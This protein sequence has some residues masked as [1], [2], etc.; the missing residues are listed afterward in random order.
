MARKQAKT[1]GKPAELTARE[2]EFCRLYA[3][4]G[5]ATQCYLDAQLP[6]RPTTCGKPDRPT[7]GKMAWQLLKKPEIGRQIGQ[8]RQAA[9]RAAQLGVNTVLEGVRQ[10]A[11]FPRSAVFDR[12]GGVRPPTDWPEELGHLVTAF[13][14]KE[15][16][17]IL[18]DEAGRTERD[19]TGMI[20]RGVTKRVYKIRFAPATPAKRMLAEWLGM[21]GGQEFAATDCPPLVQVILDGDPMS[22]KESSDLLFPDAQTPRQAASSGGRSDGRDVK[23]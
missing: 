16:V 18:R 9:V 20:I 8:F 10:Q 23:S 15:R 7:A 19:E 17:G 2:V 6:C 14:V 11:M 3:A 12:R 22:N 4:R 5:N 21:I 1:G 13:E